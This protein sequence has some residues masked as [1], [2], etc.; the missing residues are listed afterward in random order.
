MELGHQ[1]FGRVM[2]AYR[3]ADLRAH[4]QVGE[5]QGGLL[6][7]AEALVRVGCAAGIDL[8]GGQG[9]GLGARLG[10]LSADH[11]KGVGFGVVEVDARKHF[12]AVG[13][14]DRVAVS[15]GAVGAG[16][17]VEVAVQL[18]VTGQ[19]GFGYGLQGCADGMGNQPQADGNQRA[20]KRKTV[21][22]RL[23]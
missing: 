9:D 7:A 16:V 18:G 8:R 3:V 14:E 15:G 19:R 5:G 10:G 22:G 11:F 17:A 4:A 6:V 12:A 20:V 2:L 23:G 21:H 13:L 1:R